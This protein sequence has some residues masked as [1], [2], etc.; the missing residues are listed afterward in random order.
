[1]GPPGGGAMA[2]RG[3]GPAAGGSARVFSSAMTRPPTADPALYRLISL[4]AIDLMEANGGSGALIKRLFG[5]PH[6]CTIAGPG[7]QRASKAWGRSPRARQETEQSDASIEYRSY[8]VHN[9]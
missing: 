1:M 2:S 5:T 3:T 4:N 9:G 8:V 7:R 6:S